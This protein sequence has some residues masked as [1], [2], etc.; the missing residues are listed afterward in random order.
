MHH[1]LRTH[2]KGYADEQLARALRPENRGRT[3]ALDFDNTCIEGDTGELLHVFLSERLL[4]DLPRF[5]RCVALE[6][7]RAELQQLVERWKAGEAVRQEL[8][9]TL[10]VAFPRRLTRTGALETYRWATQLHAD[11]PVQDLQDQALKMLLHEAQQPRQRREFGASIGESLQV[12]GGIRTRPALV[13]LIQHAEAQGLEPWIVSATNEW[14]VDVAARDFGIPPTRVIGNRSRVKDGRILRE[15]DTPVTWRAGK[16]EAFTQLVSAD[17]RPVLAI[18]DSWTDF[19]LL[20]YAEDAIL[21]DRGDE[22]LR[23]EARHRGWG[24]VPEAAFE[25]TPWGAGLAYSATK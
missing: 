1:V 9:D 15:R 6:D 18:G 5:V 13:T 21:I 2:W 7:G 11:Q 23:S 12:V 17:R 8:I 14:T 19:E 22:A 3:I 4:W 24:I 16:V 25:T 10:I 20:G